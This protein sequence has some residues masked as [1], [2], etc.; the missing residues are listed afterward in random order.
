MESA[1]LAA[2]T[3]IVAAYVGR[4]NVERDHLPSLIGTVSAEL[5][6]LASGEPKQE[7]A[8]PAVNPKKSI[9]PDF[10]ICLEDG[11]RFKSLKRHLGSAYGMTPDDYRRKWSLPADYPMVSPNYA[12]ARSALAKATGLGRKKGRR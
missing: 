10:I 11:K 8:V 6:R 4:H 5:C 2:T 3:N 9:H 1:L 12:A 7:P